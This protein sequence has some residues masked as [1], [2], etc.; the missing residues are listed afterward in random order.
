VE[1]RSSMDELV[2][3]F[4]ITR[5]GAAPTKFDV[6]DLRPW[7]ARYL[8]TL[9]Y[10]DVAREIAD[11]GVPDNMATRFWEVARENVETRADLAD[12]WRIVNG[13][14]TVTLD[15]ADRGF[16]A[17]ALALL[18]EPPYGADTWSAWTGAVKDAT[19][20]KGKQL[21]MP[22]RLAVTGRPRGP[23]MADLMPLL[24]KKPAL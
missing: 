16:V 2:E 18:G 22:L 14:R 5:F 9:P 11:L 10:E 20:R 4:D 23:E 1:L 13:D 6:E 12:W 8:H 24:Q 15:E 3:G 17:E 7:T 19:G 21:F